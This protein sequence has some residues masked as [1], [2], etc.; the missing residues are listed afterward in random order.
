[1]VQTI[2]Q[3][4]K[5][6]ALHHVFK[7]RGMLNGKLSDYARAFISGNLPPIQP[8]ATF[9]KDDEEGLEDLDK[10]ED[11]DGPIANAQVTLAVTKGEYPGQRMGLR[12][13]S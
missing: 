9:W 13:Q 5:L 1:M 8:Y 12:S 3:L 7:N 2:S 6:N 4:Y 11:N 10:D